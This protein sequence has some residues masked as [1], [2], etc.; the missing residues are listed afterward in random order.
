MSIFPICCSPLQNSR[1]DAGRILNFALRNK[2]KFKPNL[3]HTKII[4]RA[5]PHK[6]TPAYQV[7]P[8]LNTEFNWSFVR[9]F[10]SL[11]HRYYNKG[12]FL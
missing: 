9:D 5:W 6:K 7:G 1:K 8:K 3:A 10:F 12:L 4:I 11:I 2:F